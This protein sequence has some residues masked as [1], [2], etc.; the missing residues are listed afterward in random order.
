MINGVFRATWGSALSPG[1]ATR[2]I[3]YALLGVDSPPSGPGAAECLI[4][5]LA[6]MFLLVLVL[7]RKL[8]PVE[9][10]S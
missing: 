3:W 7:E 9:I 5:L 2:R 6:I 1:W 8:R 10:I 4:V